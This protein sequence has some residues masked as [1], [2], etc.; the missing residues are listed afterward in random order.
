M[1]RLQNRF[2]FRIGIAEEYAGILMQS[3][4]Y[5]LSGINE[6]YTQLARATALHS[7][8]KSKTDLEQENGLVMS[9]VHIMSAI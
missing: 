8:P 5:Y 4:R 7:S 2:G 9:V 6:A 1:T 3:R